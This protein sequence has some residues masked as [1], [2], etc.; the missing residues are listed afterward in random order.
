LALPDAGSAGDGRPLSDG[1]VQQR[2]ASATATISNPVRL[3]TDL[4]KTCFSRERAIDALD[5]V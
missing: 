4:T 2:T 3:T 1:H 5:S